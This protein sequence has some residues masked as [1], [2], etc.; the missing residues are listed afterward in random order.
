MKYFLGMEIARSKKGIYLS[1]RKYILDL[2]KETRMFGCKPT[3]T[4][5][6]TKKVEDKGKPADKDKYQRMVGKLIY[7]SHTHLDIA[8]A[9]SVVSQ[10]I[11]SPNEKDRQAY[12][13]T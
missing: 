1:Q 10:H 8:Y 9:V 5:L 2:L 7:L 12:S 4:L 13:S 6:E 11:H 3:K